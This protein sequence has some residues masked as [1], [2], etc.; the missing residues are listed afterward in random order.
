MPMKAY[1]A[2]ETIDDLEEHVFYYLRE[3][4]TPSTIGLFTVPVG[5]LIAL[6]MLVLML[7]WA[8]GGGSS[9]YAKFDV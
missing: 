7:V 8:V 1:E 6:V 5:A 4:E 9:R 2:F 3:G